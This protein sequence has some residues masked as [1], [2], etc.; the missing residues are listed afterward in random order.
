MIG[1]SFSRARQIVGLVAPATALLRSCRDGSV[2]DL[3]IGDSHAPFLNE[4]WPVRSRSMTRIHDHEFVWHVGPRLMWSIANKGFPPEVRLVARLLHRFGTSRHRSLIVVFGEIDVR[5][6]LVGAQ[7]RSGPSMSFV[8]EYVDQ[9]LLLARTMHADRVLV[10]VPVPPGDSFDDDP[11]FPRSGTL[12]ERIG[13]FRLLRKALVAA[14]ETAGAE[15]TTLLLDCTEELA[16]SDGSLRIDLTDDGCHV[17]HSGAE[18]VRVCLQ[19]L[20]L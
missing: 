11:N 2:T 8:R 12:A 7:A 13:A 5:V 6:H 9:C 18:V 3:W 19:A 14:V 4:C 20:P 16:D 15:P 1:E 10:A 17:N